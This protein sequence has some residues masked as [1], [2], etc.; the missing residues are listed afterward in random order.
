MK[1]F[2]RPLAFALAALMAIPA[3]QSQALADTKYKIN[4]NGRI[5]TTQ[6]QIQNINDRILLP[7]REI[8][9]A[10]GAKV[11]WY[12]PERKVMAFRGNRYSFM[13][14]GSSVVTYGEFTIDSLGYKQYTSEKTEFLPVA[15][16]IINNWTY[17]PVRSI[18]E[19]L[20]A[21]VSWDAASNTAYI[22]ANTVAE[23][24]PAKPE[25]KIPDNYDDF[26]NTSYFRIISSSSIKEMYQES[27]T[28]P[29]IFVL[30]DSSK[31]SSKMMVPNIQ[32]AAQAEKYRIYG[33]D[34][35]DRNNSSSDNNWLWNGFFREREFKDP[36]VYFVKSKSDVTQ[37]QAPTDMD[38]LQK[39][40][41][42]F[43]TIASTEYNYADFSDTTYF[44]SKSDKDI[45]KDYNNKNEFI[46]VLYD[47]TDENSKQ[48][49]PVIKAAAKEKKTLVYGLD[50]DR[51]PDFYRNVS[52]LDSYRY[53]ATDNL[54]IMFLVYKDKDD[55][56]TYKQPKTLDKVKSIIEEFNSHKGT[57]TSSRYND[58]S[59]AVLK[60]VSI[61]NLDSYYNDNKSFIVVLYDSSD[62]NSQE[63]VERIAEILRTD[64]KFSYTSFYYGLNISSDTY[65]NSDWKDYRWLYNEAPSSDS[66][67]TL[68]YYQNGVYRDRLTSATSESR[69]IDFLNSKKP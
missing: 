49:I 29:F 57:S 46:V 58:I 14:I 25:V 36:T 34:M 18:A 1:K 53:D 27:N 65:N 19:T 21:A 20:G 4:L 51:Y 64:N 33:V 66:F 35:N 3:M 15:P 5:L 43:G 47:R 59:N 56:E 23:P 60:N 9:E 10:M 2:A 22:T 28:N 39:E 11:E 6:N 26:S 68:M 52:F 69:I 45:Q 61:S 48:Y 8:G 63:Y 38:K 67:P 54:P 17:I 42:K 16:V 32:D 44:K 41:A 55:R 40:I 37:I 12:E 31:E 30:Y 24:E 50:I 62:K 7:Y 13:N